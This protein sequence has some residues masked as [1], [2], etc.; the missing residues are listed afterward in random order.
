[1][2]WCMALTV[3]SAALA[4]FGFIFNFQGVPRAGLTG[5]T[6]FFG[7]A[8]VQILVGALRLLEPSTPS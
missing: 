6:L 4:F 3:L 1:M 8:L 2:R 7:S 5:G